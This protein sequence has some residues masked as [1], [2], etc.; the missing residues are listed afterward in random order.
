MS[1]VSAHDVISPAPRDVWEAL[2]AS[3]PKALAT[4]TPAWT[5]VMCRTGDYS[6]A[7]RMYELPGGRRLVLPMVRRRH[8]PSPVSGD[9]SFPPAWG[10]GGIVARGGTQPA[11]AAAVFADLTARRVVRTS[12]R[13]NPLDAGAWNATRPPGVVVVPRLAHVLALEGGFDRVWKERFAPVV[14]TKARKAER[15]GIT[16]ERDTSGRLVPVFYE[17]YERSLERWA[18]ALHEPRALARWR[19]HRRD[20][21]RKFEL[22]AQALGDACRIWVAWRDARPAAAIIVLQGTNAH[23]TRGVMDKEVAGPTGAGELLQ[24][25]AIE[26]ACGAGCGHYHMGES[27]GSASL[28]HFKARFGA[29]PY[30]YAEFSIERL[31]VTTL[32]RRA[33]GVVKRAIGFRDARTVAQ[34]RCQTRT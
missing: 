33:R 23:Y 21:R 6:D 12:L 34:P 17:L 2:L 1:M 15:S 8:L 32:D 16:V 27:G 11:D 7:S 18:H 13:P 9:A 28:S 26:E 22:M 3:D 30:A 25:L 31:P 5:D 10:M 24:R 19:G 14:R 4:Q 20:P 29:R